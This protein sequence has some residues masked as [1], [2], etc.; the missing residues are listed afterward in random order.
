MMF[1]NNLD[2]KP[3]NKA[4]ALHALPMVLIAVGVLGLAIGLHTSGAGLLIGGAAAHMCAG[5]GLMLFKRVRD[6]HSTG[7]SQ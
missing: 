5:V 6:Q 2:A 3:S 1:E 7:P 4:T